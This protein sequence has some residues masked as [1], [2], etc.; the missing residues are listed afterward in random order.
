MELH[1]D[2]DIRNDNGSI[3]R[4]GNGLMCYSP[5][6]PT[7]YGCNTKQSDGTAGRTEAEDAKSCPT[8]FLPLL[9]TVRPELH[10]RFIFLK[11]LILCTTNF[12]KTPVRNPNR[13]S[14]RMLKQL[15]ANGLLFI[16][17][18]RRQGNGD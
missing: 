17:F 12:R 8:W 5:L 2:K 3:Y 13:K 11:F 4:C 18:G 7:A 16:N 6:P 15:C 10:S 9:K 14:L 1:V